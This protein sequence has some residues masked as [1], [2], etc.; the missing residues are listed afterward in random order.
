MVPGRFDSISISSRN[1]G[2]CVLARFLLSYDRLNIVIVYEMVCK[3]W[4]RSVSVGGVFHHAGL[5][6]AYPCRTPSR[7]SFMVIESG[8]RRRRYTECHNNLHEFQS[9]SVS[10][11]NCFGPQQLSEQ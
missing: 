2:A 8:W 9:R 1:I 3:N 4:R 10:K 6:P 11:P 7:R 5:E